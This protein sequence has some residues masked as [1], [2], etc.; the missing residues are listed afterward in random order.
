MY[1]ILLTN[2]DGIGAP[3]L[4][5][6]E[7]AVESLGEIHVVAPLAEQSGTSRAITIRRP[8]RYE[9]KGARRYA[10][11]GTPADTMMMAVNQILDF[12]PDLVISGINSGPNLGESIY[13]SGTVSAAAEAAK[14]GV[15]AIAVSVDARGDIDFAPA[16]DFTPGLARLVLEKGLPVGVALNVNIPEPWQGGIEITRQSRKISR[17]VMIETRDPHGR[18]Y[19]WMHEEVPLAD[20]EPGTDYAAVREGSISITPIRFEHTEETLIEPLGAWFDT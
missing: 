17:N 5:A 9:T 14:Y 15:A 1:R 19:Y 7:E 3:G 18:P 20:A 13:Y 8:L 12:R 2:D 11:D 6:L 10:V 16:A 4:H